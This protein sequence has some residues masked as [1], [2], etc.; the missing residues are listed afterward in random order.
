MDNVV[1]G[2]ITISERA[3]IESFNPAA[4]RLFGYPAHEVIGRNVSASCPS[5]IEAATTATWPI[6]AVRA[7]RRSSASAGRCWDAQ[8]RIGVSHGSGRRRVSLR[9]AGV[10]GHRA[11]Y[12][13][14]EEGHLLENARFY[15][16]VKDADRRKDEFLAMLAHELRN[17]LAPIR[18]GLDLLEMEG[19]DAADRRLGPRHDEAPGPA[20]G[21]A[22]R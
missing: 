22:G 18:S 7:C 5:P 20:F 11:R 13:R 15:A 12:Q 21:S 19:V 4:Q 9:A 6:T 1:D 16:E 17:P 2:I 8:G 14:A 3:I 10:R